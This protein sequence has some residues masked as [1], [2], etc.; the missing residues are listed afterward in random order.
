MID[1]TFDINLWVVLGA[2]VA[3]FLLGWL[4]YSPV[5]FAKPWMALTGKT[6]ADIKKG[7][8]AQAMITSFILA[9]VEAYILAHFIALSQAMNFAEGLQIGFWLALG[10]IAIPFAIDYVYSGKPWKLYG[11]SAGYQF[12]GLLL[13]AGIL[14]QWG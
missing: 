5:L 8:P 10:F 4:W 1:F 14:A 13:M 11:I 3:W 7:N 2:T 12:V 6:N 9:F